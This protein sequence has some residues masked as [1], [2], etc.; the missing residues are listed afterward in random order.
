SSSSTPCPRAWPCPRSTAGRGWPNA[1]GRCWR[2]SPMAPSDLMQQ[3][4]AEITGL[5]AKPAAAPSAPVRSHGSRPLAPP[6]RSVVRSAIALLLQQPSL[7]L[8]LAPPYR[9]VAL[10]QPGIDLLTELIALVSARP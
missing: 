4:L 7:A 5:Q 10:R 3:R 1:R 2:R 8:E 9:F 6:R